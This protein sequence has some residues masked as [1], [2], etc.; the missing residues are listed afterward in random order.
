MAENL[1]GRAKQERERAEDHAA[2]AFF[3]LSVCYRHE[4]EAKDH[5]AERQ[6]AVRMIAA[7]GGR[8]IVRGVIRR[9]GSK[10]DEKGKG[11]GKGKNDGGKYTAKGSGKGTDDGGGEG[12]SSDNQQ[13]SGSG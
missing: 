13:A 1:V 8:L 6:A 4:Q 3:Q 11:V 9:V 7:D 12:V 2:A 5:L 10:D